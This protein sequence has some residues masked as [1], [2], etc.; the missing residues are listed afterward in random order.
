MD[1]LEQDYPNVTF[2]YMTG[3]TDGS[4]EDGTLRVNNRM[5]RDFCVLNG[6][7]LFD[8]EDIE[9]WDPEGTYYPDITDACGWCETWCQAHTCPS[10]SSCAHSHCFNC[11]LK[12]K[13]FWWLLARLEGWERT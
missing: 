3:H 2:V 11:F 7:V 10:C 1:Q 6:K 4:G 5:I 12:G 8:F 9:S 13:A